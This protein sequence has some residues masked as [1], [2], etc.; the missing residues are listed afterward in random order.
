MWRLKIL[1]Q[2]I[3]ARLPGGERLN[4]LLQCLKGSHSQGSVQSRLLSVV[5]T[6]VSVGGSA[7]IEGS[8]VVEIGT[9]WDAIVP[10]ILYMLGARRII[11]Y[12]HVVHLRA[13]RVRGVL[14]EISASLKQIASM[15]AI[16][17]SVLAGRMAKVSSTRDL[18]GLLQSMDII[19]KAPADAAQTAL[20]DRS[21]DLVFSYAVMEHVPEDVIGPLAAEARRILKPGGTAIH[22][23]GLFD[24]H[25]NVES[26]FFRYLPGGGPFS[27]KTG[28]FTTT[29]S[30]SRSSSRSFAR[31]VDL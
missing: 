12:D 14:D 1:I 26:I 15:T 7:K 16:P 28:S 24:H 3:L 6:L 21:V 8:T 27:H 2:F 18:T 4:H 13:K 17:E 9:G 11:T 25:T 29:G 20:P 30:V 22:Y 31:A 5:S 19:Y 23:I 10:A